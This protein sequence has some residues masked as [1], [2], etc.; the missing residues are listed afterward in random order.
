MKEWRY[1]IHETANLR[2]KSL[3]SAMS[4]PN[5]STENLFNIQLPQ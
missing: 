1:N 3:Y 4:E 2:N 5:T